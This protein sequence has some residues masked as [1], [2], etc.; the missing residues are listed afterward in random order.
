MR[1]SS[2]R[3]L[4]LRQ[5]LFGQNSWEDFTVHLP[6]EH[7]SIPIREL[8]HVLGLTLPPLQAGR[9]AAGTP[10]STQHSRKNISKEVQILTNTD[11]QLNTALYFSISILSLVLA[12][13]K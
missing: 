9:H 8:L 5:I 3:R 4:Q 13:Y 6:A 10:W 11:W 1:K 2:G 12:M 7:V